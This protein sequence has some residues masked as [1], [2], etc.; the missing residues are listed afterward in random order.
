MTIYKLHADYQTKIR[1]DLS[2][3]FCNAHVAFWRN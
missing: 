3:D 2:T 1:A